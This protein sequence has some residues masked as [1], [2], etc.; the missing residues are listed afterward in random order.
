MKHTCYF[1][2]MALL[3]SV[4]CERRSVQIRSL[5]GVDFGEYSVPAGDYAHRSELG[6]SAKY[7]LDKY[8]KNR[9]QVLSGFVATNRLRGIRIIVD[10]AGGMSTVWRTIIVS[11]TKMFLLAFADDKLEYTKEIHVNKEA[12]MAIEKVSETL[13]SSRGGFL[14]NTVICDR[15]VFF[16]TVYREQEPTIPFVVD[17]FVDYSRLS[18][19]AVPNDQ[20]KYVIRPIPDQEKKAFTLLFGKIVKAIL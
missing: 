11:D 6:E 2:V 8:G 9:D 10:I 1:M 13:L 7:Y 18:S 15:T 4:G 20:K 12:S 3:L 16:V 5:T 17:G 14:D 19:K